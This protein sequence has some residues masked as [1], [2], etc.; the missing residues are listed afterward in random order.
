MLGSWVTKIRSITHKFR[1]HLQ[2]HR[3]GCDERGERKKHVAQEAGEPVCAEA[4][5]EV[6]R[7]DDKS[8]QDGLEVTYFTLFTLRRQ[9]GD[10][11]GVNDN[12]SPRREVWATPG[13]VPRG[14][15]WCRRRSRPTRRAAR[16]S[17]GRPPPI[18][19]VPL[20][21]RRRHR[22]PWRSDWRRGGTCP[23]W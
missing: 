11:N 18:D 16:W 23:R 13:R 22:P 4:V 15:S 1:D 6:H 14:S 7:K 17:A 9:W 10:L 19:P 8:G 5:R 21:E 20:S 2:R 12:D 3:R